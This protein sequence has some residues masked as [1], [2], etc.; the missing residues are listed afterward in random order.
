MR[1]YR[2]SFG[3]IGALSLVLLAA[4][5]SHGAASDTIRVNAGGAAYIDSKGNKWAAD[6]GFSGGQISYS[7]S[8]TIANTND[9]QLHKEE[10]WNSQD[11]SYNFN[12]TPGSY[13]VSLYEATLYYGYCTV[14]ARVFDVS[15]NGTKVLSNY[16]IFKEVGCLTAQIKQFIV[17]TNDGKIKIEFIVGSAFVP[18]INAIEVVPGTTVA[19]YSPSAEKTSTFSISA[20]RGAL[21]VQSKVAGAYTVEVSNLQGKRLDQKHGFGFGSQTFKNLQ[22]GLYFVTTRADNRAITRTVSVV[23]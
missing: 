11:F 17:V 18:K 8:V 16:D 19:L 14:G 6:S 9:P 5:L 1:S 12:V 22:P 3:A 13:R 21:L 23:R 2:K 7:A 20:S 4:V 10:R 15:I